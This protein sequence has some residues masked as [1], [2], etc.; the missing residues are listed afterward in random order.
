MLDPKYIVNVN[1]VNTVAAV[2]LAT[3]SSIRDVPAKTSSSEHSPFDDGF[4]ALGWAAEQMPSRFLLCGHC[5]KD[6]ARILGRLRL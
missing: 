1:R 4:T 3:C 5:L 6:S 2:H